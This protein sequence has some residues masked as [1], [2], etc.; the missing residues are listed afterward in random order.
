MTKLR[1]IT[2]SSVLFPHYSLGMS[3]VSIILG[4]WIHTPESVQKKKKKKKEEMRKDKK[5][6]KKEFQ[7]MDPNSPGI[8]R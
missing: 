6:E 8:Y 3:G 4:R 2:Q 5:K 1:R 7:T